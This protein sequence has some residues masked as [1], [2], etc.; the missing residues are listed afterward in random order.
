SSTAGRSLPYCARGTHKRAPYC[1]GGSEPAGHGR[2]TF[3]A[4]PNTVRCVTAT[5]APATRARVERTR[6]LRTDVGDVALAG[7]IGL[8]QVGATYA[9]ARHQHVHHRWDPLAVI[10]LA[11]GPAAL[12]VRR[13]HPVAVLAVAEATALAYWVIGYGRGPLFLALIVA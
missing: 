3:G 11:A 4:G 7:V 5:D 13:R 8:I 9:A 2:T 6:P 1:A 12:L 10:L